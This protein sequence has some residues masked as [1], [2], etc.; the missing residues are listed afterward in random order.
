M[1]AQEYTLSRSG[2]TVTTTSAATRD[3]L[4][5]QGWVVDSTVSVPQ[6][7]ATSQGLEAQIR[8]LELAT[9]VIP[10]GD[11]EDNIWIGTAPFQD[12]GPAGLWYDDWS[13]GGR[14]YIG[15]DYEVFHS[16][17]QSFRNTW[18][19]SGGLGLLIPPFQV[20][21]GSTITLEWWQRHATNIAVV[22]EQFL[23]SNGMVLPVPGGTGVKSTS[24]PWSAGLAAGVWH[25]H[26]RT[27]VV[28]PDQTLASVL[29]SI[30]QSNTPLTSV[31]LDDIKV[32]VSGNPT[33]FTQA[34]VR[35]EPWI[36]PTLNAG[37]SQY[38]APWGTTPAV[39]FRRSGNRV[40][41]Q[42]L[43][44]GPNGA[45]A[46]TLPAGYRP[47]RDIIRAATAGGAFSE[48]RILSNG[49]VFWTGNSAAYASLADLD[50]AL[51]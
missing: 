35:P 46:F 29:L 43:I 33:S 45:V 50:F 38:G 6:G 4:V 13:W 11:F 5:T 24:Y 22:Q 30:E 18:S 39:G 44:I 9:R 20:V 51:G 23:L 48:I 3:Y 37:W 26:T 15:P 42:G 7:S 27:H 32:T 41:G 1:A 16:G 36:T 2:D 25:K 31:W 12:P 17:T 21:P 47:V 34:P 49:N 10:N 28:E 19:G 40:E 14:T 8:E